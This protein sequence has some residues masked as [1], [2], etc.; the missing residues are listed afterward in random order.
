MDPVNP[1]ATAGPVDPETARRASGAYA[2][3]TLFFNC[4]AG[5]DRGKRLALA[6]GRFQL[7]AA[8]DSAVSSEDPEVLPHHALITVDKGLVSIHPLE[9]AAIFVDGHRIELPAILLPGQQVRLGR[10]LW[11][12]GEPAPVSQTGEGFPGF[13]E[14]LGARVS[15]AAGLEKIRGFS[16]G[17]MFSEVFKRRSD[18]EKEEYFNVGTR[19]TTPALAQVDTNWPKPWAFAR[20]LGAIAIGY[21]LMLYAFREF[22][23]IYFLPGLIVLGSIAIPF[24]MLVFFLEVNVPRNVSLYQIIKMVLFG[25]II[26]LIVSLFGFRYTGLSNWMGAMSAG[27]VEESGKALTLLLFV[28]NR[29]FRWTLNGLLIGAAVGT[30]FS[31]FETMGYVFNALVSSGSAQMLDLISSRGWLNVLGDHA[32]WTGLVGAALWRVRGDQPFKPEMLKDVRFLRVLAMAMAM[33]LIN[34]APFNPPLY[35]KYLVIGFV[36]WAAILSFVQDG[37]R[38]VRQVQIDMAKAAAA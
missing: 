1:T 31:V 35:A 27:I 10:S 25:G 33:H 15:S 11:Q 28:R 4:V 37:L 26:S 29:R 7:G 18:E 22:G 20:T 36:A 21:V 17:T 12:V 16:P 2:G 19:T 23:N 14:R 5:P 38:Q 3:G 13:I 9:G 8:T 24:A 32:L 34:N 30:G 6:D